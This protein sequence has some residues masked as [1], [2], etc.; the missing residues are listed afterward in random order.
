MAHREGF[1]PLLAA[2][3]MARKN[4][5]NSRTLRLVERAGI[6]S[7]SKVTSQTWQ[8]RGKTHR[9]EGADHEHRRRPMPACSRQRPHDAATTPSSARCAASNAARLEVAKRAVSIEIL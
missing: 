8:E 2:W 5:A 6:E 4:E 9:W 3:R 7:A 1:T